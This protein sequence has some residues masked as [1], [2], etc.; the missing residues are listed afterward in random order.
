VSIQRLMK[1]IVRDMLPYAGLDFRTPGGLHLFVP[2][3]G[4]W[5]SVGE[6]FIAREYDQVYSHLGDVRN[7]VDLG[8][9]QGFFSFALLEY[10]ARNNHHMPD[11]RVFL[12]DANEGCVARVS[13]AIKNNR[14]EDK[15]RCERIVIGPPDTTVRFEVHKESVHSN[16]FSWGRSSKC[17][18]LPTTNISQMFAKEQRLFDLIKIDI[19]GAEKFLFENHMDFLK[20]FRYGLCEWHS[21]V[22]T[23]VEFEERLRQL[24]WRVVDFRSSGDRYDLSLG[25][26]WKS[27][28]GVALWENPAP[29][30]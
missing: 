8:C 6:I 22:F 9:N 25:N 27:P 4:A 11:T 5:S 21:P 17:Q 3:R 26:S 13:A 16:I 18:Q 30:G 19:E 1:S 29:T 14:L 2:D 28:F 20:R 7:W 10:F 15:W 24:K 12:G 23:G